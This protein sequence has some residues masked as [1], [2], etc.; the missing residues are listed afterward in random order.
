MTEALYIGIDVSKAALDVA[1]GQSGD[2]WRVKNN[3]DGI[4]TLVERLEAL[5]PALVV[6]ESTG[7]YELRAASAL[8]VAGLPVTVVNPGRVREFAKSIGQLAKTDK[9][10]ARLLAVFAEKVKP[11]PS[12]LPDEEEQLLTGLVRRRRQLLEM[13]TAETNR[14]DTTHPSLVQQLR[15]HVDWLTAEIEAL[16]RQI[17]DF[18]D[19]SPLWSQKDELLQSTP[20]VGAV[21][22]HT[23]L[24][25]VPELGQ[26]SRTE[27]AALIGVAPLNRDSGAKRGKRSIRGGRANVRCV[28]YMATLSATR[29]NPVIRTFYHRLLDNGK[30]KMVA[31]VACMRK[32][33]VIL[34]AMA[35]DLR[36]WNPVPALQV[37]VKA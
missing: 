26:L 27:I 22:S 12:R 1:V 33:L 3:P 28:L 32:L 23:L 25:E 19:H 4:R 37:P 35:R 5:R 20:G 36:P 30:E 18:I 6:L 11:K 24:A 9:L 15:S 10:D 31:I 29:H 17:D 13:R 8:Y 2:F 14:L 21:L 7:G 34:N 16:D